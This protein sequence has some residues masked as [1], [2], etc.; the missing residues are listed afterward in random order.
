MASRSRFMSKS[1]LH[2]WVWPG[3]GPLSAPGLTTNAPAASS[4]LRRSEG[5]SERVRGHASTTHPLRVGTAGKV[6][7]HGR[8]G[9]GDGPL[10]RATG[11]GS[12][13]PA[14]KATRAAEPGTRF[15]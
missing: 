5:A 8:P 3:A 2:V 4:A 10:A 12:E 9:H 6:T 15:H 13:A 1:L 11:H 7:R 14:L